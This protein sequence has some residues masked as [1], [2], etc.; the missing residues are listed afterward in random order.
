METETQSETARIMKGFRVL[1]QTEQMID[2]LKWKRFGGNNNGEILD[3]AIKAYYIENGGLM[4]DVSDAVQPAAVPT[5][6]G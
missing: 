6:G 1:P 2:W 3:S 5:Q 4:E